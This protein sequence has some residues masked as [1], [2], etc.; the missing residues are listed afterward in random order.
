MLQ[1]FSNNFFTE[2]SGDT[3]ILSGAAASARGA[4]EAGAGLILTYPGSP[5]VETFDILAD[6]SGPIAGRCQIVINEHVA[7]HKAL[8]YSLS[9]G[10]SFLIM[11]HVGFNVASDPAHYS[12]YTGVRGGMVILIG[13][14]PGAACSTGE[15]DTRFN[16]LHTHIPVIEPRNFQEAV[17]L[18]RGAFELSESIELPV[19]IVI[20]SGFCYGVGSVKAGAAGEIRRGLEFINSPDYTNVGAR[21]AERHRKLSEKIIDLETG[22]MNGKA[23]YPGS[24]FEDNGGETLI[25]ASGI[26]LDY[27]RESLQILKP[28]KKASIYSPAVTYPVNEFDLLKIFTSGNYSRVIFA[29]DLEGF[30]ELQITSILFKRGIKAS[31]HGKDVFRRFGELSFQRV[32]ETLEKLSAGDAMP[33]NEKKPSE[34]E[35]ASELKVNAASPSDVLNPVFREGTFC[36]GCPHRAFFYALKKHLG[37]RDV[38]GGDIGCSS[39]PPHF[40]SWLTCMNSGTSIAAGVELAL[41][42]GDRSQK[43]VSLIG[44]STLFHSGLQTMIECIEKDSD[45]ICFIL[46]NGWTAMTGHQPTPATKRFADGSVNERSIEIRKVLEAFGAKKIFEADPYRLNGFKMILKKAFEEGPGFTVVIISHECRLLECKRRLKKKWARKYFISPERCRKCNECYSVLTCPAIYKNAGG[47]LFI[48]E[49]LCNG[50]SVCHQICPNG[51]I[52]KIEVTP[53]D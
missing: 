42:D 14:D 31:V 12:A 45:Q 29:E 23:G 21:A 37:P 4:F 41:R 26:Y 51:A 35:G 15:F 24:V 22:N 52:M 16:S 38:I 40:S 53:V 49:T 30:L 6:A 2:K 48:D 43:V 8:G 44:D 25:I 18:T 47:D 10:R 32:L 39:L 19:I 7:Y 36:P 13:S 28:S 34:T 27:V 50:C 33:H 20:P 5:V 17:D 11:K 9:G 46:D 3:L 1:N